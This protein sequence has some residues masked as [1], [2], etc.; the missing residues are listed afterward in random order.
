MRRSLIVALA[1]AAVYLALAC[2]AWADICEYL[3]REGRL[4]YTNQPPES[5]WQVIKCE[6]AEGMTTAQLRALC[7]AKSG[8]H[9]RVSCNGYLVGFTD[10]AAM[11]ASTLGKLPWC[12]KGGDI[13]ATFLRYSQ[14]HPNDDARP[15]AVTI[16]FAMQEAFPCK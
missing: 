12:S 7:V 13:E 14:A 16:Y 6:A 2:S 11:A 3:D 9:A 15:A 4:H 10:G 5:G 1:T 8:T